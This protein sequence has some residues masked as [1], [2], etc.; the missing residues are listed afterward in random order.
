MSTMLS[1]TV[2]FSTDWSKRAFST[3]H[4]RQ[5]QS[6][7]RPLTS[8]MVRKKSVGVGCLKAFK[9]PPPTDFFR[10]MEDVSGR[11]LDWFWREWFVENARFDQ[12]VEKVTVRDSMVDITYGNH[13]RGVLPLR[14]RFTFADGSSEDLT[15]PAEVWSTNTGQY[16]RTYNF[17][18]MLT[19]VEIDPDH[20]L[21]D[22][23]RTN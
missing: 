8:S 9:H 10:T 16:Q 1:R 22:I 4:S 2:T 15:Y 13:Q 12:S 5:N 18:K 3:N 11:R 19:R 7:R 21:I 14:V 17:S 23:D 20:R 6:S